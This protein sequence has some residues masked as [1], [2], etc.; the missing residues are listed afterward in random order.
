METANAQEIRRYEPGERRGPQR[1][2]DQRRELEYSNNVNSNPRE[3]WLTGA[4][5]AT[6]MPHYDKSPKFYP[7]KKG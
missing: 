6:E 5:Q 4:V 2:E 1:P 7:T 3:K